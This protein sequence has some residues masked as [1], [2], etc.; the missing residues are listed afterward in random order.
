M[1]LALLLVSF[2]AT[3]IPTASVVPQK[4]SHVTLELG[5]VP[6]W[7]G[8]PK[9]EVMAALSEAGYKVL[10]D[11][12]KENSIFVTA[13]TALGHRLYTIR[14]NK[15][16]RLIYADRPWHNSDKNSFESILGALETVDG[17]RC[18]VS[19]QPLNTPELKLDRI[20]IFCDSSRTILITHGKALGT[21]ESSVYERIESE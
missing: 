14:F 10:V 8:M 3:A 7:L 1:K 11:D 19:H 16:G 5:T 13:G 12:T 9:S 18:T 6:V 20:F 4:S 21:T 17:Q 15:A 2:L